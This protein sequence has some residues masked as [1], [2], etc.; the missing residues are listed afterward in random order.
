M[1]VNFHVWILFYGVLAIAHRL[2][3]VAL[4]IFLGKLWRFSACPEATQLDDLWQIS[5]QQ[6]RY[7]FLPNWPITQMFLGLNL[8]VF[9]VQFL[10][11][12]CMALPLRR[13]SYACQSERQ[14]YR[15]LW[16]GHRSWHADALRALVKSA[17]IV[18]VSFPMFMWQIERAIAEADQATRLHIL[19]QEGTQLTLRFL[20]FGLLPTLAQLETQS[21]I[22]A[23]KKAL[24]R[25]RGHGWL[26][27]AELQLSLGI[28]LVL[29]AKMVVDTTVQICSLVRVLR[30]V[31]WCDVPAEEWAAASSKHLKLVVHL[32][33]LGVSTLA[34]AVVLVHC[35]MRLCFAYI[36]EDALWDFPDTCVKLD[37]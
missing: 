13:V 26:I 6:S 16:F 19:Y 7:Y 4:A 28:G 10:F 35:V 21:V 11:G 36:C 34:T 29:T 23:L 17:R 9:V 27:D 12:I 5:V 33:L 15:V 25:H 14:G 24:L 2:G 22:F 3:S 8:S 1:E 20:C 32:V 18:T 31:R 37:A 30:T